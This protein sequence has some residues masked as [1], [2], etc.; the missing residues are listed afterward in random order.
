LKEATSEADKITKAE[1][2]SPISVV[3]LI[4]IDRDDFKK[5]T[6]FIGPD[7]SVDSNEQ[8]LIRA[9]KS[10]RN[11]SV[12]VVYQI[13]FSHTKFDDWMHFNSAYDSEG[14]SLKFQLISKEILECRKSGCTTK[15]IVGLNVTK[16]YLIKN[17]ENG[18]KIQI[19][20]KKGEAIIKFP[21]KYLKAIV[22]V[23]EDV[24]YW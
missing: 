1:Q 14:N 12:I 20:G 11:G 18:L 3:K 13:Y 19:S 5:V 4:K 15:E 10:E 6:T 8:S 2:L 21:S 16:E 7:Y 17:F 23:A 9:V 24:K 22:G